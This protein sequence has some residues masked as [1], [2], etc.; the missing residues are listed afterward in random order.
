MYLSFSICKTQQE[1]TRERERASKQIS[2][3]KRVNPRFICAYLLMLASIPSFQFLFFFYCIFLLLFFV[4][5]C[6]C[7][8][9]SWVAVTYFIFC[10]PINNQLF[11]IFDVLVVSRLIL[12]L[13]GVHITN[14]FC[15]SYSYFFLDFRHLLI[16]FINSLLLLLVLLVLLNAN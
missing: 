8:F 4:L 6:F 11:I 3:N 10:F 14:F 1:R 15:Y 2:P 5:F 16:L 9:P 7:F 13:T 12:A